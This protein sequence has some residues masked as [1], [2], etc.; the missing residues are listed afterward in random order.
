MAPG[1]YNMNRNTKITATG[2]YA[3]IGTSYP[4]WLASGCSA[5]SISGNSINA[6]QAASFRWQQ[7]AK[8]LG[9]PFCKLKNGYRIYQL[10]G[11]NDYRL[12][13][14]TYDSGEHFFYF[15]HF[16]KA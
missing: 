13:T 8:D 5:N 3:W 4:A 6:N 9:T 1:N 10:K 15:Q 14:Y 7:E 2:V 11:R 12:V 16:S